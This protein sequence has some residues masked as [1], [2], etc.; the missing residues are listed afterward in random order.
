MA[1]VWQRLWEEDPIGDSLGA[2]RETLVLWTQA[3]LSGLYVDLRVPKSSPGRSLELAQ[4]AG[5]VPRPSA[6]EARG[7][8]FESGSFEE[9]ILLASV[10]FRQ[11]S[12]AGMLEYT[13]GDTTSGEALSKDTLLA[14][15]AANTNSDGVLPLCTCFWKREIDYQPPSGGLDIGVCASESVPRSLLMPMGALIFV[16][17]EPMPVTRKDGTVCQEQPTGHSWHYN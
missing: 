17:R 15:I 12:F 10:L 8:P 1:G 14:Q 2:D 13:V 3:P 5:F 6:L 16:K 4:T 11:K 9:Q 7:S